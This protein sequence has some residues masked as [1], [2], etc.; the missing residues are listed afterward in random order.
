MARHLWL[1]QR[2]ARCEPVRTV[3]GPDRAVVEAVLTLTVETREIRLPVAV[4]GEVVGPKLRRVRVYHSRVP[5]DGKLQPR[6]PILRPDASVRLVEP[7]ATLHDALTRNDVTAAAACFADARQAQEL[8]EIRAGVG[9]DLCTVIDDGAA[10]AVEYN[11]V[12]RGEHPMPPQA[13][14]AVYERHW[15]AARRAARLYGELEL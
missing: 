10:C 5:L 2:K 11:F 4:A 7:I 8:L 1:A 3:S 6:S 14:L 15:G 13:A 9:I 12:S